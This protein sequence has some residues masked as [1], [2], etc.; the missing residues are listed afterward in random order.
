MLNARAGRF[1]NRK[2]SFAGTKPCLQ[3]PSRWEARVH[4]N[5]RDIKVWLNKTCKF[6]YTKHVNVG[7]TANAECIKNYDIQG[8]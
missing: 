2:L 8:V 1:W 6:V 4:N 7:G 5:A 3:Q